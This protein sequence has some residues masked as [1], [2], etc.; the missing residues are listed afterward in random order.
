MTS[1]SVAG[2]TSIDLCVMAGPLGDDQHHQAS[3]GG[4]TTFKRIRRKTITN[5]YQALPYSMLGLRNHLVLLVWSEADP[6]TSTKAYQI[7]PTLTDLVV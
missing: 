6:E 1:S 2:L 3:S 4:Q 5:P 7:L